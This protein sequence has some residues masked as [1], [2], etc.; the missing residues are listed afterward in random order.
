M[1]VDTGCP[2]NN[3]AVL[4]KG[5]NDNT[6]TMKELFLKLLEMRV[7][8]YYLF[9]TDETKSTH[10]FRASVDKGIE[11]IDKLRGHISGLAIPHFVI[12]APGGGGK[13]PLLPDYLVHKDENK[14]ILRNYKHNIYVYRD[15]KEDESKSVQIEISNEK[16]KVISEPVN[17]KQRKMVKEEILDT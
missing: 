7:R 16:T 9:M 13:I 14:L 3:Q 1:L 2:V 15:V 4:M 8:P 10:H 12:D 17:Y 6:E 5:I 11:I